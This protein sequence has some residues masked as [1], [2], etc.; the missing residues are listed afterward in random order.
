M[1]AHNGRRIFLEDVPLETVRPRLLALLDELAEPAVETLALAEALDR[2]S[3]EPVYARLSSP[4]Y[5][6][7]AMDGIA[8]A[9]AVTHGARE[10]APKALRVGEQAFFVDTG[11]PLPPGT[12]AVIMIEE[13]QQSEPGVVTI[14]AAVAPFHHVRSLGEDVVASEAVVARRKLLGPADLAAI[15]SA[16]VA[17]S[18]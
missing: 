2:V 7:C 18:A 6:A 1:T 4:H 9:A 11:D 10:T 8:V 5:H 12:D 14:S 17:K 16:G 15:A 13:V 3:A